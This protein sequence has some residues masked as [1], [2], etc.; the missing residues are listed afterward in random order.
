MLARGI[1]CWYSCILM[2]SSG[3]GMSQ[4][5]NKWILKEHCC[6]G[7]IFICSSVL[8][9]ICGCKCSQCVFAGVVYAISLNKVSPRFK[10]A[11]AKLTRHGYLGS[12]VLISMQ[13]WGSLYLCLTSTWAL[14]MSLAP[15]RLWRHGVGTCKS[16]PEQ[17]R[18]KICSSD[19]SGEFSYKAA[20]LAAAER[21]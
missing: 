9:V 18:G 8:E 10:G 5:K 21:L 3:T 19:D 6:A 12:H 4:K 15:S 11:L 1:L 17:T 16:L 7:K 2:T 14:V 20:R 13:T